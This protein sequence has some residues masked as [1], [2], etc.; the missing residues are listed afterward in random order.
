LAQDTVT[1]STYT[2]PV[3]YQPCSQMVTVPELPVVK[4]TDSFVHDEA[5]VQ[6]LTSEAAPVVPMKA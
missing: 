5:E 1:S 4:E 3:P 6:V 2:V